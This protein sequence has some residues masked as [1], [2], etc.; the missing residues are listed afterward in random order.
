[1]MRQMRSGIRLAIAIC[2]LIA[3]QSAPAVRAEL[4]PIYDYTVVEKRA[5]DRNH[6]TQGL[7]I[8]NRQ[9]WVS[10]GLY[11]ESFLARYD[12]PEMTGHKRSSL[13]R[14]WFAEGVTEL[15]G[16]LYMLTWRS[17]KLLVIDPKSLAITRTMPLQGEG[18]G[19][20]SDGDQLWISNGTSQLVARK[21]TKEIRRINVTLDGK[22][23]SRLNEL[24]WVDGEIWANLWLTDQIARI[25]PTSGN[26]IGI[27]D[28]QGLL[29]NRDRRRNTD[30]LNGIAVDPETGGVWVSGKRWPYLFRIELVEKKN[31]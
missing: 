7:L 14:R 30:V 21:G 26:I 19:I 5:I 24:E 28:L 8:W 6:F 3:A 23:V 31:S 25:D 2:I 16:Q 12:W 18:W 27:I 17:G 9:L 11:G 22:R 20:T 13:P 10:S 4:P 29:P 1:M 15:D